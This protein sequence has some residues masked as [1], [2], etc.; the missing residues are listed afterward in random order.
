MMQKE[1]TFLFFAFTP[2]LLFS[3][4]NSPKSDSLSLSQ[5][6]KDM[7]YMPKL[8]PDKNTDYKILESIADSTI[9]YKI[10]ESNPYKLYKPDKRNK[11]LFDSLY[12]KY[13]LEK[14]LKK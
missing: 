6:E 7:H 8:I 10:M 11:T 5:R 2:I 1:F 3:Q 4:E 14:K 13:Q 12:R 9:D